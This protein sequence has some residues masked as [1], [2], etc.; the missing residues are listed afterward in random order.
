MKRT[1][2]I[3][4]CAVWLTF[5]GAALAQ[6][7]NNETQSQ[8]AATRQLLV[9]INA[10]RRELLQQAIEFQQ[11]KLNQ[12]N[13]ELQQVQTEQQRLAEEEQWLQQ[14]IN[15]LT[16]AS[17]GKSELETLKN[18]LA[19]ERTQKL[20]NRQQPLHERATE[21][22]GQANKEEQRLRQLT[23]KLKT[24]NTRPVS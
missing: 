14:E 21:L 12:I 2:I 6:T 3:L 19:G 22:T 20:R 1:G 16:A 24:A 13:R 23:D 10:L 18:E 5:A 8:A 7:P 11:W 17:D 9:E 4:F 15:E